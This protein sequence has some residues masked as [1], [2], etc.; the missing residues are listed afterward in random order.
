MSNAL[1]VRNMDDVERAALAMSKSGFFQ[2]AAQQAQAVVKILAGQELGFGPF[3]SMTGVFIISGKP[4][5]SANLMAAAVKRHGNGK[6]NYRVVE[7]TDKV[8]D[9][10][11]FEDGKEVGHS[12]FTLEDARKAGTKN[13]DKYPRNM[14]F[15]RA[16]SNGARWF[17]P[18]I[19]GGA[20]AYTPEELGADV[21]EDGE[22]IPGSFKVDKVDPEPLPEPPAF[23]LKGNWK[24]PKVSYDLACTVKDRNGQR[25]IDTPLDTLE[26]F[27][28]P[29]LNKH[30]NDPK[31]TPED[32]EASELKA[33]TIAAI[34]EAHCHE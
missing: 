12:I 29:A 20:P 7:L 33:D 24:S 1:I 25:Y 19:F 16:M 3:A 31:I 5:F 22:V 21:D 27:M 34:L 15:A 2:D 30:I 13:L 8:C 6:Y 17:A 9:L 11:F 18:D 23:D 28:L 32:K 26:N 10:V 4:S 14:L